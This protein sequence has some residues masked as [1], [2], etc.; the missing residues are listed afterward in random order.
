[1]RVMFRQRQW[2][3]KLDVFFSPSK[4][5]SPGDGVLQCPVQLSPVKTGGYP[6][7]RGISHDYRDKTRF[8]LLYYSYSRLLREAWESQHFFI[9]HH[10]LRCRRT[11]SYSYCLNE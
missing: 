11:P 7:D 6:S 5:P 1:M 3:R 9:Y 8:M 2:E 4:K 10:L